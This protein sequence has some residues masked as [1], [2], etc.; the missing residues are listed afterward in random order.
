VYDS[1]GNLAPSGQPYTGDDVG[2]TPDAPSAPLDPFAGRNLNGSIPIPEIG[3]LAYKALLLETGRKD[4]IGFNYAAHL[5]VKEDSRSAELDELLASATGSE[6]VDRLSAVDKDR[7]F[8]DASAEQMKTLT[9]KFADDPDFQTF[10]AEQTT[11]VAPEV[12]S[13]QYNDLLAETGRET[14]DDFDYEEYIFSKTDAE[15]ALVKVGLDKV[16]TK[17]KVAS[18]AAEGANSDSE[19]DETPLALIG[20]KGSEK[21]VAGLGNDIIVSSGGDDILE[22]GQGRDAVVVAKKAAESTITR[23][24]ETKQWVVSRSEGT[25]TLVD[26]ERVIFEDSTIALDVDK[27]QVGGQ[28]ALAL[29]ALLGK[30][31]VNDPALVGLVIGLLDEGMPFEELAS[32]AIEAL[33]LTDNESLVTTL[34]TNLVGAPPSDDDKAVVFE[35]LDSGTS[36]AELI[37]LAAF[38]ELNEGNVDLV[39]I[40]ERGLA[41]T[42]GE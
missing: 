19:A 26:V 24:A 32:R 21:V 2:I 42:A 1:E 10:L 13:A 41:Y 29:G 35:L 31:S 39:G 30:D 3:S 33:A 25:D 23:N 20:S 9:E 27:E 40:A 11:P 36:P 5:A 8:A 22:G 28:A 38:N 6:L 14:L 37:R 18:A 34:W 4:L 16:Y 12:G 7:L 15:Q 17:I